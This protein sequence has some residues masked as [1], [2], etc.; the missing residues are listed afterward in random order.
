M[1]KIKLLL[2][3]LLSCVVFGQEKNYELDT[4]IDLERKS[5]L[6]TM[7]AES[8]INANTGNYDVTYHKLEFN[9]D[10]GTT[11][12]SG[13]VTTTF[14]A[15]ELLNSI[16]FDFDD[17]MTVTQVTQGGNTLSFSQ[18]PQD[19]LIITLANPVA[20]GNSDS[21]VVAYQ[22][23]PQNSGLNSFTYSTHGPSNTP[24]LW[25]LSEPY[26]AKGWWP[27]KQDLND[28]IDEVD[29]FITAPSNYVAV[30]NGME[31]SAVI[32]GNLKTTHFKHQ[33]LI[34]AYL[35]AIAVTDYTVYNHTV[36]NG[37]NPFEIVNYVFPEDAANAQASTPVTVDIMDL[38]INLFDKY[39]FENEKYGHAQFG[40]GG[41]MEHTTV[42]FMGNWN[43]GL[44]AHELAHQWFG[45]KVTCGSW[46]D[47]W[48][49]EGFATYLDALSIEH[50]DGQEAAATWRKERNAII[51]SEPDGS[52]YLK[53]NDTLY[54]NRIF[55]GRL[56][57]YKGAMVVH[58]LRKELGDN[59][60]FQSLR[61]YLADPE[62]AYGYAKT[63]DLKRHLEAVS[64]KDLTEFFDD[65][66]YKEGYPSFQLA[67]EQPNASQLRLVLDQIQSHESVSF[68]EVKMPVRIRGTN[69]EVLDI[70]LDHT[71]ADQ[72]YLFPINFTVDNI[73]LNSESDVITGMN[74]VLSI[75]EQMT[76]DEVLIYPNPTN[77]TLFIQK[78]AQVKIESVILYN[79]L[80]QQ[81]NTYE[82]VS[83]INVEYLSSGVHFLKIKTTQAVVVKSFVKN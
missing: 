47:I 81:L 9:V 40:W 36:A 44:I 28:K 21:V 39:P 33:Y 64:G 51:T 31:Q 73:E 78:P 75:T 79:V 1:K 83:W 80:G 23:S 48:L 71:T 13:V 45:N 5:A 4:I 74:S 53:D 76:P 59:D 54:V 46:K 50:I 43:R 10:P 66:V 67:W 18:T 17:N 37:G 6:R 82:D 7:K 8:A 52:V 49:N 65:W 60:F 61:N 62:L 72:E 70:L 41:G 14:T 25:T 11:T 56:S 27:C 12:M 38:F 68:F 19:E 63:P 55:N 35:I 2:L 42:S 16:I 3:L 24:I 29:I 20:V 32:N 26:G 57:Y 77:T 15:K 34:P 69:G 22:G 30:A 58:M